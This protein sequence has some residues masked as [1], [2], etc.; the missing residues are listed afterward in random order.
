MWS[1]LCPFVVVRVCVFL[2]VCVVGTGVSLRV[3]CLHTPFG[4]GRSET[5]AEIGVALSG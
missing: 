3:P 5:K 2:G 4:A 1:G